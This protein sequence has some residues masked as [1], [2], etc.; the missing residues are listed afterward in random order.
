MTGFFMLPDLYFSGSG[1]SWNDARRLPRQGLQQALVDSRNRTLGLL[2]PFG[3][4]ER[5][6]RMERVE[7]F[8]PPLWTLGHVAWFAEKWCLREVRDDGAFRRPALPSLLDG[9]DAWF[10]ADR[11]PPDARWEATLPAVSVV[12]RYASTVLDRVLAQLATRKDDRDDTLYAF[13][14]ALFREDLLGE[15]LAELSQAL[16]R[17][18]SGAP[19]GAPVIG[20][21]SASLQFPGGKFT[22]GWSEPDGFAF[23]NELPP[24]RT[25]V[26][27]F[28]I[29]SAPVSNRQFIEF[30]EDGGYDNPE[31]WS[32]AGEQWL[33]FQERSAPRYWSRN[34]QGGGWLIERFGQPCAVP[35]M[36][37]VRHISLFEA[38]AWCRW[39]GRRLPQEDEWEM[40]AV[41]N[42]GFQWGQVWEWTASPFEPYDGFVPGVDDSYSEPYF[43]THQSVRGASTQ[44]APRL[45]HVR[46]RQHADPGNDHGWIGFRTCAL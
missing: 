23:D 7:G 25:Y 11:I 45:R 41:Q 46:F 38:Q 19:A 14:L 27:P 5:G 40:A 4:T 20:N 15:A 24:Q 12:K 31:W 30:I 17:P 22:L 29:D 26:P 43:Q 34:R 16:G 39:A 8:D 28:D 2:A 21:A 33:M 3:D 18:L 32:R 35:A 1:E 36:E 42:R 9:A 6:W 13:R 37:P 44:T 10:D